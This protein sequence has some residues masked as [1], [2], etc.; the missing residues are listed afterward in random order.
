MFVDLKQIIVFFGLFIL[1]II[2]Y[3]SKIYTQILVQTLFNNHKI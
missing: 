1:S 3:F 2:L